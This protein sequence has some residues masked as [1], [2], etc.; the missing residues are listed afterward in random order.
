MY[1]LLDANLQS[2]FVV[3]VEQ[4]LRSGDCFIICVSLTDANSLEIAE[5]L[6]EKLCTIKDIEH[7]AHRPVIVVGT[8]CD[9]LAEQ[10][11]QSEDVRQFANRYLLPY[12]EVSAKTGKNVNEVFEE[13]GKL[14][15]QFKCFADDSTQSD[16]SNK[17]QCCALL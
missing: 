17:T 1:D 3:L 10:K 11:L 12:Y 13:I 8:K 16:K 4:W 15:L 7:A 6:L 2:E 14:H 9:N 5:Q